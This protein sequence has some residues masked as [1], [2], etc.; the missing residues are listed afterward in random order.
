MLGKQYQ[1]KVKN[2]N[3]IL[4]GVAQI[5]V[6]LPSVRAVNYVSGTS[7]VKAVFQVPDSLISSVPLV[8][9]SGSVNMVIPTGT[10]SAPT[11][12]T[13]V[14]SGTYTG[15]YDG[16]FIIRYN[17]TGYDIFGPDGCQDT[18]TVAAVS[19]GYNMKMLGSGGAASGATVTGTVTGVTTGMTFIVPVWS[20]AAV[21]RAQTG[22]ISPYPLFQ[23]DYNSV[24]GLK[25]AKFTPK[26]DETKTLSSGT[27]ETEDDK[28]ITKTSV[29]VGFEALEYQNTNL[30]ALKNMISSAINDATTSAVSIEMV[31]RTRGNTLVTFWMP[32]CT[33]D[34]FPEIAPQNDYSGFNWSLTANKPAEMSSFIAAGAPVTPTIQFNTWQ[35]LAYVYRE[36]TFLH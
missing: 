23:K 8:D 13:L 25:N 31:C 1:A 33:I 21:E 3:D 7:T 29:G 9:G 22:I 30:A 18:A 19:A 20:S 16:A 34:S 14:S 17:G 35:S 6:G 11:S 27:P 36:F 4:F 32:T 24:G 26:V 15:N 2:V 28:L 5:R 12:S 10:M